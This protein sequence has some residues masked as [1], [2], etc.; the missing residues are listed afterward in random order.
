MHADQLPLF[1]QRWRLHRASYRP[2]GE[3]IDPRCYGVDLVKEDDARGFVCAHHYSTSYPAARVRV[4]LFHRSRARKA[5][6]VGVAVFSVPSNPLTLLHRLGTNDAIELGRF[7]LVDEVP[8]NG[9]TWFL[10]RA[11]RALRTEIRG[12]RGVLAF[13]DPLPRM[14]AAGDRVFLGH[15]GYAYQG[16]N[17][18]YLGRSAAAMIVLDRDGR[19][20]SA[21]S[22]SKL[23]NDERGARGV[24]ERLLRAGAPGLARGESSKEYVARAL[25]SDAFRRVRHPG[26]HAYAWPFD[27]LDLDAQAYPKLLD[28]LRSLSAPLTP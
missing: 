1:A 7:V 23:R 17:A 25:T 12:I 2:A 16:H 24:Y 28:S 19:T 8:A 26:N 21:R 15:V 6:L 20:I 22:L 18:S 10:R 27:G 5:A 11:F 9:E 14:N 4:G 13:S 3:P